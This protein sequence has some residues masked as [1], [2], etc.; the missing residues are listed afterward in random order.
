MRISRTCRVRETTLKAYYYLRATFK[1][2]SNESE[3]YV[4]E[5]IILEGINKVD[6][7]TKDGKTIL[8]PNY[9]GKRYVI[10]GNLS[11]ET[12]NIVMDLCDKQNWQIQEC[13]EIMIYLSAKERLTEDEQ[14]FFGLNNMK[15]AIV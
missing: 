7:I 5:K 2:E 6:E 10:G 12:N 8:F 9:K 4:F 13:F 15:I 3:S 11:T 1:I 14:N